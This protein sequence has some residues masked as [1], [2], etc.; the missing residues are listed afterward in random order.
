MK[1]NFLAYEGEELTIEWYHDNKDKSPALEYYNELSTGQ[2]IKLEYLFRM[3][4]DTGKIRSEEKFRNEGDQIYAFKIAPDRFLCF[5]YEGGK[6]IIT[7]AFVKKQDKMPAK[8]KTKA[9]KAR[10]DYKNRNHKGEYYE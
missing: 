5:F 9:I 7:N 3:L 8:E 1:K 2:K 4:G 6:V 10:T